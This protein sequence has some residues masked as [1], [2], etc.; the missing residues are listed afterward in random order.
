[1]RR[2]PLSGFVAARRRNMD[3]TSSNTSNSNDMRP[4]LDRDHQE[5]IAQLVQV[6]ERLVHEQTSISELLDTFSPIADSIRRATSPPPASHSRPAKRRKT[7]HDS[8]IPSYA[9]FKYG[10]FGQVVPGRLKLEIVYCDGG[11]FDDDGLN[12]H[13][14]DNV[15]KNDRSVYCTKQNQCNL[16]LKHQGEAPFSIQRIVIKAP[17]KGFTAPY[18]L[19]IFGSS[20][21]WWGT[22]TYVS[23]D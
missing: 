8:T 1:M 14:A 17:E 15:L 22:C 12:L 7:T 4:R 19:P 18:V 16:L 21:P 11:T 3:D 2:S 9:G 23:Q 13:R 5:R 10:H 20:G 6:G